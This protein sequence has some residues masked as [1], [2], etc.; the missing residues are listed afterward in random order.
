VLGDAGL[1]MEPDDPESIAA[2]IQRMVGDAPLRAT[3]AARGLDRARQFTW[4]RAAR[5]TR[6]AYEAALLARRNRAAV[7]GQPVSNA[8]PRDAHRH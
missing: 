2:S 6:R 7:P 4:A 3:C 8:Q 5:E 1:L